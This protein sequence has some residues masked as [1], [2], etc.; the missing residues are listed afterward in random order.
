VALL[1]MLIL[2]VV[3]VEELV[4]VQANLFA[5]YF[6]VTPLLQVLHEFG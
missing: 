5:R 4:A 6:E 1:S 2:D 3:G